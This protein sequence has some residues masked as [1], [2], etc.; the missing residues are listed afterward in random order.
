MDDTASLQ[1][2]LEVSTVTKAQ[3]QPATTFLQPMAISGSQ[4]SQAVPLTAV[5]APTGL[6][7]ITPPPPAKPMIAASQIVESWPAAPS[8]PCN[9]S[10]QNDNMTAQPGDASGDLKRPHDMAKPDNDTPSKKTLSEAPATPSDSSAVRTERER[11]LALLQENQEKTALETK[12]QQEAV[13]IMQETLQV[14]QARQEIDAIKGEDSV[15]SA[16]ISAASSYK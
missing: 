10:P 5:S 9:T 7:S 15:Y 6:P 8:T 4:G 12:R 11:L 16:T 1:R 14:L 3:T 2:R 13:K